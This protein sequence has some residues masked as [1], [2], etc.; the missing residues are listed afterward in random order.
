MVRI[1]KKLKVYKIKG[2]PY[3]SISPMDVKELEAM[4]E[5]QDLIKAEKLA[6]AHRRGF[7]TR[8]GLSSREVD[9]FG[10]YEFDTDWFDDFLKD[11]LKITRL[12]ID[13]GWSDARVR[14]AIRKFYISRGCWGKDKNLYS[15]PHI[16]PWKLFHYYRGKWIDSHPGVDPSPRKFDHDNRL[17]Q[18]KQ[19]DAAVK[20]KANYWARYAGL[21]PW[22][23]F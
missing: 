1:K 14:E 5:K 2:V 10:L 19:L 4:Q 8:I 11:R 16:D 6:L 15:K 12:A 21:K 3:Q 20:Q 18:V 23:R 7:L 9:T 17:A 22:Q 13:G